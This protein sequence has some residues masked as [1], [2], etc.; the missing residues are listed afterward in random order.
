MLNTAPSVYT[1]LVR[2]SEMAWSHF[3]LYSSISCVIWRNTSQTSFN[4]YHMCDM[5]EYKSNFLQSISYVWYGGIQVKLPSIHITYMWY[6]GIQVKLA[7]IH[8]TYVWYGGIQ[9]KLPSIHITHVWYGGIQIKL[10][11]IHIT[12]V[13]YGGIQVK[14]PSI[15]ITHAIWRNTSQTSFNP[16]HMCDMEEYKSNFLQSI[17][18]TFG[19]DMQ[20]TLAKIPIVLGGDWPWPSRSNST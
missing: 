8:I 9:V 18:H 4:P 10:P 13:W 11:S 5:E 6:G 14:F 17:S 2:S 16:Y 1:V 7:S 19:P 12:H 3:D 15:H 20:N